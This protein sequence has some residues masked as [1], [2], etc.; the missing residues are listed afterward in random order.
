MKHALLLSLGL[1][2]VATAAPATAH[3]AIGDAVDRHIDNHSWFTPEQIAFISEKCGTRIDEKHSNLNINGATMTCPNGRRV[4]DPQVK[5]IS[6]DV[7]RRADAYVSKIMKDVEVQ[8]AIARTASKNAR[9]AIADAHID[10]RVAEAM[11]HADAARHVGETV[12]K[13]LA[14][15]NIEQQ[16]Q[17]A[18]AQADFARKSAQRA[19]ES[20]SRHGL[21]D[22]H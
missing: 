17:D 2:F 6:D 1:A 4:T 19:R 9:R 5:V 8:T 22:A 11:A 10:E 20:V 12:R 3:D 16:V 14:D 13:A 18:L 7:S 21:R 15:A